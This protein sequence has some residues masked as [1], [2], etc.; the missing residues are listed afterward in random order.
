MHRDACSPSTLRRAA[1]LCADIFQDGTEQRFER[2]RTGNRAIPHF[3][4]GASGLSTPRPIDALIEA[5][6][7]IPIEPL[8]LVREQAAVAVH[9]GRILDVLPREEAH[10]RYAPRDLYERPTHALLPGFV[11]AHTHAAMTLLRGLADDLPLK[12][13]LEEHIWPAERKW[14]SASFVRDGTELAI[15]EMLRGGTTCFNDMYFYPEVVAR[16]AAEHGMRATVG[17]IVVEFP[18]PWAETTAEYFTKGLALHDDYREDPLISTAFAP[19][20]PYSVSDETLVKVRRLADQLDVP[21][22]MHVHESPDEIATSETRLGRRPLAHL[23]ELG[24][25]TPA[26]LAVHATQLEPGEIEQLALHGVTVI[27][28]PESNLKLANGWCPVA[29]LAQAGVNLALGTDGAASNNDLDMLAEM[30][31]AALLAKAVARDPAA[32]GAAQALRLA[33]LGGAR[34]LG[35][36]DEIGALTPGRWADVIAIDLSALRTQPIFDPVSQIVYAASSEQVTDAWVAGRHLLADGALTR[37]DPDS[38]RARANEWHARLAPD[39][40]RP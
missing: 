20:A 15:A 18:T 23:A 6:W 38:L 31:T 9:E 21:I 17:M 32:L 27:H 13:W 8:G 25:L 10:A 35:L 14:M 16:A 30:R 37:M 33:T 39:L 22:H 1:I 11:N 34:A 24:L 19:H 12:A 26:L 28:C 7:I 5:R 3:R 36:G 40:A 4:P 29:R 2:I